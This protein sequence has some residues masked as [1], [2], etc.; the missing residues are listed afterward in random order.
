MSKQWRAVVEQ[1][2]A[3]EHKQ[4]DLMN[5]QLTA[6]LVAMARHLVEVHRIHGDLTNDD[7]PLSTDSA[8]MEHSS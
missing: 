4:T 8:T 2:P 6:C 7:M 3:V 1:N 5:R